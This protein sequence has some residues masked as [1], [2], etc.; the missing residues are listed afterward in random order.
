MRLPRALFLT[1][2]IAHCYFELLNIY[3]SDKIVTLSTAK[4]LVKRRFFTLWVQ[5]DGV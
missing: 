3:S 4:S 2:V 1:A 5:N